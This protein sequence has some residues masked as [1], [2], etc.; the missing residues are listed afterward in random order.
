MRNRGIRNP[1]PRVEIPGDSLSPFAIFTPPQACRD[2]LG[3]WRGARSAPAGPG[4][5]P[6]HRAA[7]QERKK[8][9][10]A[11]SDLRK[12]RPHDPSSL[13]PF[14]T[15]TR[16]G[17]CWGCEGCG[18]ARLLAGSVA[19]VW[20]LPGPT[21]RRKTHARS[22]CALG[23]A[24]RDAV[25]GR[26]C[27]R[28]LRAAAVLNRAVSVITSLPPARRLPRRATASVSPRIVLTTD[29]LSPPLGQCGAVLRELLLPALSQQFVDLAGR[30]ALADDS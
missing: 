17:D 9:A 3:R 10:P 12:P 5:A 30:S 7:N 22:M 16:S 29:E 1:G 6:Q 18:S 8:S 13:S 24:G 27:R 26:S 2:G 20:S 21:R 23:W 14:P 15:F 28:V 19:D 4:V 11:G 25:G